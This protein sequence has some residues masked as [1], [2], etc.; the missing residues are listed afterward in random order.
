MKPSTRSVPRIYWWLS[1]GLAGLAGCADTGGGYGSYVETAPPPARIEV[2]EVRPGQE[3]VWVPGH[4][5]WSGTAY[6]WESGRWLQP[7]TGHHHY[8]HGKWKHS[9]RGWYWVDGHWR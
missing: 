7:E 6:T 4:W 3:Y 2:A 9:N 1:I 5:N 8:A